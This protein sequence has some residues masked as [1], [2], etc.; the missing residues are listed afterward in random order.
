M[1]RKCIA[2]L[3]TS[4]DGV[5]EAPNLFQGDAFDDKL[6]ELIGQSLQSVDDVVLGR[7]S[8]TEWAEYWPGNDDDFGAFINPVRKHVA[9]RT[10]TGPLE[11]NNSTLIEGD[12]VEFVRALK[13]TDG[14]DI[15]VNGSI[16]VVRQL[17]LAGV[18]DELLLTV[19]PVIAGSGLRHLFTPDEAQTRLRLLSADTTPSGNAVLSYALRDEPAAHR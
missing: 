5:V 9:S 16:S 14:G 13:Q 1:P 6:G 18:I 12:L 10:L 11:W 15:A 7:V 2:G 3:F 4:I 19:H 8:Y 17:F